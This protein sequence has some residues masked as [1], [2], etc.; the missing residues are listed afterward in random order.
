VIA[1]TE[2]IIGISYIEGIP[3]EL[4]DALDEEISAEGVSVVRDAR[5]DAMMFASMVWLM[6]TAFFLFFTKSY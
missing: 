3:G 2:P 6:P 5:P 4:I 1:P